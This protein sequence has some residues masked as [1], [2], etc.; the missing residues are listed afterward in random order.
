MRREISDRAASLVPQEAR[1]FNEMMSQVKRPTYHDEYA[2]SLARRTVFNRSVEWIQTNGR[3]LDNIYPKESTLPQ[4]GQGAF[5]ARYLPRGSIVVPVPLLVQIPDKSVLTIYRHEKTVDVS[6]GGTASYRSLFDQPISKQL[7]MNYCFGH[8]KSTLLLCPATNANLINHCSS[9]SSQIQMNNGKSGQQCDERGPNAELRWATEFDPETSE[10]L[11]LSLEEIKARVRK[12]HRGLSLE[13]VATRDIQAGDEIFIDY[14]TEWEAAWKHH[15][16]TWKPP[17][18]RN[19]HDVGFVPVTDMNQ[20][21]TT[22]L[23]TEEERRDDPYPSHVRIGCF[24]HGFY[25]PCTVLGREDTT[26]PAVGDEPLQRLPVF[27]VRIQKWPDGGGVRELGYKWQPAEN[28][29]VTTLSIRFIRFFPG[30]YSSDQ[31]L[32]GTFRKNIGIRDDMWPDQ[33]KNLV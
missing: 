19:D 25:H 27:Q 18:A 21:I 24:L 8:S 30:P 17:P 26:E 5:A 15:L 16:A 7:I 33:W 23:R 22:Y 20:N 2:M 32:P 28:S 9:S 13:I 4:A 12:G 31:H 3:C 14:G 6:T 1:D 29:V 10:W 11:G